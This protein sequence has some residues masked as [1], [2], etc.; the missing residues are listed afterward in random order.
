MHRMILA[1]FFLA[2]PLGSVAAQAKTSRSPPKPIGES[3]TVNAVVFYDSAYT[4]QN[5]QQGRSDPKSGEDP[6]KKKVEA[7]LQK[8][9]KHFNNQN[10]SIKIETKQVTQTSNFSV[11]YGEKSLNATL[12]LK[13]L[14][15]YAEAAAQ[16]NN[17][18]F[19]L[20]TEK[21][22]YQES[23]RGDR[24]PREL[25][26]IATHSTFCSNQASAAVVRNGSEHWQY[27]RLV[28]ATASIFGSNT[29]T[30]IPPSDRDRMEIIFGRCHSQSI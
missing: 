17:T 18:V 30:R 3:V 16:S 27:M 4:A 14:Q 29:Y 20:L 7:M 9:Q 21:A 28:A 1:I 15:V 22:M 12:T 10:I 25:F 2:L 5:E 8:A 19:Y 6:M 13:N 23:R 26:E 11:P 24:I